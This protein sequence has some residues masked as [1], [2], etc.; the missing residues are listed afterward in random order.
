MAR[1]HA[2]F[3][4]L[5]IFFSPVHNLML[6]DGLLARR[7]LLWKAPLGAFGTYAYGKLAYNALSV[8]DIRYPKE[9]ESRIESTITSSFLNALPV[10]NDG[11]NPQRNIERP[12]KVLEVG[13]GKE[14]RLL[15]RGL[16]DSGFHEVARHVS[17]L[18]LTG[19]DFRVATKPSVLEDT[20]SKLV[21]VQNKE[22]LQID[23]EVVDGDIMERQHQFKDG[24]FDCIICC[25]TLCSVQDPIM[26]LQEIKRLLKPD[27]GTFG[28]IEHVAVNP[29]DGHPF[30]ELQQKLL[31]PIQQKL[32]DNCHLHR[33]T[34]DTIRNVFQTDEKGSRLVQQERFYVDNM[35]P[36]SCQCCGV[37]QRIAV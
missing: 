12:L 16:Y 8:N 9:I 22:G 15:R 5:T 24:S 7:D 20:K 18:K 10:V 19:L 11:M 23:L 17:R 37:I 2:Q 21:E 4:V 31:D 32:A 25:L 36:V 30:L 6:N 13:I 14:N 28:Y 29:D 35:W 1:R 27:G 34:E 3:F 33:Y 26:A